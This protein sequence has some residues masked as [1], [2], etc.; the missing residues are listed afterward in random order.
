MKIKSLKKTFAA[1]LAAAVMVTGIP[2]TSQAAPSQQAKTEETA[3][4][5]TFEVLSIS[6]GTSRAVSAHI[7]VVTPGGVFVH[8]TRSTDESTRIGYLAYGE[9]AEIISTADEGTWTQIYFHGYSSAW[10]C[11][12]TADGQV[13]TETLTDVLGP[14]YTELSNTEALITAENGVNV[15]SVAGL[16]YKVIAMLPH[17]TIVDA[18]SK[19]DT[20]IRIKFKDGHTWT[21]GFISTE[22]AKLI[23]KGSGTPAVSDED[24]TIIY[25]K[26]AVVKTNTKQLNVHRSPSL[27]SS[28]INTLNNGS[29]VMAI[30]QSPSWYEISYF[31]GESGKIVNGYISRLY[32]SLVTS[33]GSTRL[34]K[35]KMTLK[36]GSK[37]QLNILGLNALMVK[38]ITWKSAKTSIATVSANGLV[39]AKKPGKVNIYGYYH[40]GSTKIRLKCTVTVKKS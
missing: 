8:R 35:T 7:R 10:V 38:N 4:V 9:T 31:D 6:D 12:T 26:N 17:G 25:Y 36:T 19:S 40:D 39:T 11:G 20:W 28:V 22:W 29:Q 23:Q 13:L 21:Q 34:N 24:F 3:D 1:V 30:A 14:D 5:G 32:S 37:Y 33:S 27:N 16:Q 15:H 2:V 18:L